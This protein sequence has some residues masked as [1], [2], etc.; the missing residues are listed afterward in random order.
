MNANKTCGKEMKSIELVRNRSNKKEQEI[1]GFINEVDKI[2][3]DTCNCIDC[4]SFNKRLYDLS[5]RIVNEYIHSMII[6]YYDDQEE[7]IE[8]EKFKHIFLVNDFKHFY[9]VEELKH[10]YAV[11]IGRCLVYP[12]F[13][14]RH[15]KLWKHEC[16]PVFFCD[17]SDFI[18]SLW[19]LIVTFSSSMTPQERIE[20]G[21]AVSCIENFHSNAMKDDNY[22]KVLKGS[23]NLPDCEY[24]E[25][26]EAI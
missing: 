12:P 26:L 20:F 7:E 8:F 17:D 5:H 11:I 2:G 14:L 16:S 19:E 13:L 9:S 15:S 3:L 1:K 18:M 21:E 23:L 22:L 10:F 6:S 25:E 24:R 4:R